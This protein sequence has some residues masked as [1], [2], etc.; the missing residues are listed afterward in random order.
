MALLEG[1]TALIFGIANHRSIGWAIAQSLA[2]EGAWLAF[3]YQDRMEKY[4]RDL[5]AQIPNTPVMPCDVQNDDELDAV[6]SKAGEVFG[7]GLDFLIHYVGFASY[8]GLGNHFLET[9]RSRI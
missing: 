6:F 5:A 7:G 1:K 9:T 3:T 2:S 4:V 8:E